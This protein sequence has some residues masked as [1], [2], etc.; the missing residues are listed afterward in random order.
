MTTYTNAGLVGGTGYW[1]RVRAQNSVGN[2][3]YAPAKFITT[4]PPVVPSNLAVN[5]Y[6]VG[7]TRTADL[8]WTPGSEARVDVWRA[9]VKYRSNIVN[10]GANTATSG[11]A[12]GISV[13]YQVCLVGK[14]D[15][16]SCTLVVNA[17]Y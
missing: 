4:L 16:A 5:A 13:P 2:S 12:L 8:T 3:A 17:N 15:A 14:T 10:T 6:L 1:Y 7:T 11:S 9:G